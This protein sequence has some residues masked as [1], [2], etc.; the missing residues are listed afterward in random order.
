[1]R[2][3]LAPSRKG[4]NFYGGYW[5]SAA[6]EYGSGSAIVKIGRQETFNAALAAKCLLCIQAEERGGKPGRHGRFTKKQQSTN[7]KMINFFT[8]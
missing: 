3:R 1:M 8:R 7:E 6:Y 2:A 5:L 4:L